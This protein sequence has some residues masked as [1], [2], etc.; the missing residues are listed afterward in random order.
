[1]WSHHLVTCVARFSVLCLSS[2]IPGSRSGGWPQ[3]LG[4]LLF[5]FLPLELSIPG[6]LSLGVGSIAVEITLKNHV[7]T[8]YYILQ[9]Q[10]ELPTEFPASYIAA[11]CPVPISS[12]LNIIVAIRKLLDDVI[13]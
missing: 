4:R 10:I 2:W 11:K 1:M 6:V 7:H 8:L 3:L 13:T 5:P 12:H 9:A